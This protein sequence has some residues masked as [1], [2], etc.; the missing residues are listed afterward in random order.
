MLSY[1]ANAREKANIHETYPLPSLSRAG[2]VPE[3]S[4]RD[5]IIPV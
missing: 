5:G 3:S 2:D 1:C 4:P